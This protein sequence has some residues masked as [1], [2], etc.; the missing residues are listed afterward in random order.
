MELTLT[1]REK[2]YRSKDGKRALFSQQSI[3]EDNFHPLVNEQE[4]S[5]V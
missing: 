3:F 5:G 1:L 4:S 2:K